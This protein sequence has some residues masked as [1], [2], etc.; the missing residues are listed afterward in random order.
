MH[1]VT[2]IVRSEA[3]LSSQLPRELCKL[4]FGNRRY[5]FEISYVLLRRLLTVIECSGNGAGVF[6]VQTATEFE[7]C[8]VN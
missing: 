4:E 1:V 2:T 7:R 6:K 3:H 8:N 5:T